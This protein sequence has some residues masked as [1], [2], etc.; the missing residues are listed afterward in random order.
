MKKCGIY[1]IL[2]ITN[3]K[4]YIGR[5]NLNKHHTEETLIGKK[6]SEETR[7]RIGLSKLGRKLTEE[8]KQKISKALKGRP[9]I[10]LSE[11]TKQKISKA[12][13]QP[14]SE[15]RRMAQIRIQMEKQN[16]KDNPCHFQ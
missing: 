4:R 2:N 10:P 9:G 1:C 8:H 3:G 14:W 7:R 15:A 11:E 6:R 16:R 13:G 5:G 12:N